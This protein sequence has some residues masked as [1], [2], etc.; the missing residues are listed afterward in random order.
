MLY[1]FIRGLLRFIFYFLGLKSEGLEKLPQS[2][3]VIIAANHV[4]NWDPIVV[5]IVLNRPVYFMGKAGLFKYK[6]MDKFFSSLNAFPVRRGIPDRKA[7][8][9]ALQI[10]EEG[11]VLGIFPEGVRNK[12]GED[13]KAQSGVAMI[14]LKS[15]A[16]ILPVAC[17]GTKC[18]IPWGWSSPLLVRVGKL[19]SLDEFKDQKMRSSAQAQLSADIMN[20]INGLLYK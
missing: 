19:I 8:R 6:L 7:I 2:G 10:L 9:K 5:A 15:G 14:A 20:K 3:P 13:L 17:L 18:I 16:P 4:S 11:N 1:S 12:T